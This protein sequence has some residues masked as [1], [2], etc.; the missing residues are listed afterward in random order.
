[1]SGAAAFVGLVGAVI[2]LK[3]ALDVQKLRTDLERAR[4]EDEQK[5]QKWVEERFVRVHQQA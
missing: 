1:L 4:R 3:I 5:M 2:G